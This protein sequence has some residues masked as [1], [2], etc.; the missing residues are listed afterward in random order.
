M[1]HPDD[2]SGLNAETA[3][4]L[5][6]QQEHLTREARMRDSQGRW[7]WYAIHA[8]ASERDEG[9]R[10]TRVIG[11]K[12]CIDD[13]KRLEFQRLRQTEDLANA[14]IALEKQAERLLTASREARDARQAAKAANQAKSR[15]LANMSH[16]IRTPMVTI[17]GYTEILD[18]SKIEAGRTQVERVRCDPR[19]V[20]IPT[21][22]LTANAIDENRDRCVAAGCDDDASK[23]IISKDLRRICVRWLHDARSENRAVA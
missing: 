9:G 4:M 8:F 10:A 1:I 5:A 17:L 20:W 22:A 23:P 19:G 21:I 7:F 11:L 13:R 2:Q 14:K 6:G 18:L 16:E 15:F 12:L 3:R